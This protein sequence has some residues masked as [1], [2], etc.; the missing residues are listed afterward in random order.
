MSLRSGP[1]GW[2]SRVDLEG[3][4]EEETK[5]AI[6]I[7]SWRVDGVEAPSTRGY[8]KDSQD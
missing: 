1:R 4:G 3:G 6:P 2:S 5:R 8:L 7:E